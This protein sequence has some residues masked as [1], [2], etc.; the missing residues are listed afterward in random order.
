MYGWQK[1][2]NAPYAYGYAEEYFRLHMEDIHIMRFLEEMKV[3]KKQNHD[4]LDALVSCEVYHK[5]IESKLKEETDKEQ[6]VQV[7]SKIVNGKKV[8]VEVTLKEKY[9]NVPKNRYP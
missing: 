1:A 6:K 8:Y 9:L 4:C 7:V 3:W 2:A 5:D